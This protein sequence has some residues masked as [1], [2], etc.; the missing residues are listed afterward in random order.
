MASTPPPPNNFFIPPIP[1]VN[2]RQ[3]GSLNTS[4]SFGPQSL[5]NSYI[6]ANSS[7]SALDPNRSILQVS[8]IRPSPIRLL[9]RARES[10]GRHPLANDTTDI[11][12]DTIDLSEGTADEQEE[13]VEWGMVDRMRLW[14]HD[15]LM[16]HL[17]DS[18]AF[19]GDKILSWTSKPPSI[20]GS[21]P[22]IQ[23]RCI[24][25]P[26][27]AFWLAQTF[28]MTHQYARAEQLLI[29]AFPTSAVNHDVTKFPL[30]NGRAYPLVQFSTVHPNIAALSSKGKAREVPEPV[31]PS[32]RGMRLPV[33]PS[34]M[35]NA[36][37]EYPNGASR[38]VDMSVACRYLAALCQVRLF[39]LTWLGYAHATS[40][41]TREVAQRNRNVR[42]I[43]PISGFR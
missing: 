41:T 42:R 43:K 25:D 20:S 11:F 9:R 17:F 26:N 24:D 14:R 8:P 19:W 13:E 2:A 16:Q 38:L 32:K 3:R 33:G 40:G 5:V 6:D 36:A 34:S 35:V 18:A 23:D 4:F 27:D 1:R 22:S 10:I 29:R 30:T 7:S 37:V 39:L 15:A 28:F 31:S 12:Q 21:G